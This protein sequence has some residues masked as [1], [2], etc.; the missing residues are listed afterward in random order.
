MLSTTAQSFSNAAGT[1]TFTVTANCDW[2]AMSTVTWITVDPSRQDDTATLTYSVG[3]NTGLA[4]S[5]SIQ[6]LAADSQAM[7]G[8]ISVSQAQ[9]CNFKV[10]PAA[11][12]FTAAGGSGGFDATAPPGCPGPTPR[13]TFPG[14][15]W[16]RNLSASGSRITYTVEPN[17]GTARSADITLD[18]DVVPDVSRGIFSIVQDGL[19]SCSADSILLSPKSETFDPEPH[20]GSVSVTAPTDC[21]WQA[22]RTADWILIFETEVRR[23]PYTVNFRISQ[24]LGPPRGAP[25]DI[26]GKQFGVYQDALSCPIAFTCRYIFSSCGGSFAGVL[27]VAHS[28][29]DKTL[30]KS[31]R[32]RQYTNLYYHFSREAVRIMLSNPML[33]LR[34]R[35]MI[36]RFKPVLES[37]ASG[38]PVTLTPGDLDDI[39]DFLV[40]FSEKGSSGLKDALDS[41]RKDLRDPAVHSD[42]NI[43]IVERPKRR[44]SPDRFLSSPRRYYFIVPIVRSLWTHPVWICP[45]ASITLR[46]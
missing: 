7:V 35:D 46:R 13:P 33:L 36:T 30:A 4:R 3:A 11:A 19:E 39:D 9:S 17:T 43:S 6:I 28:F 23:G 26:G 40:D 38:Q 2:S 44:R 45:E 31:A 37:M 41:L 5:G 18:S 1:G 25:I 24:N 22:V 34:S 8:T 29:R 20:D 42:F 12:H 21:L 10:D 27:D 14:A 15:E 16:V 32:G